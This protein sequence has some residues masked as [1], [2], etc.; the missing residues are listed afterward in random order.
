MDDVESPPMNRLEESPPLNRLESVELQEEKAFASADET[1]QV[2]VR[3]AK[4]FPP[5]LALKFCH[6]KT[7]Q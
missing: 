1:H 2:N 5:P 6:E 3:L 7:P 4:F